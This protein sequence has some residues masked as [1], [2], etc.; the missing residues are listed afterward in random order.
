MT[1]ADKFHRFCW[2]GLCL[3]LAGC[4]VFSRM[5]FL[6]CTYSLSLSFENSLQYIRRNLANTIAEFCEVAS[7]VAIDLRRDTIKVKPSKVC[8]C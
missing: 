1:I 4:T 3:Q 5:Y 7:K 2:M 6:H 8:G